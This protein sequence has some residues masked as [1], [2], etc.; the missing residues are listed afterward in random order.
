ME[1]AP[2]FLQTWPHAPFPSADF[3]LYPLA[4]INHSWE[5]NYM[6][7]PMS[8]AKKPR[9]LRVAGERLTQLE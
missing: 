6:L 8:S 1:A 2:G 7:S 9:N 3:A 5:Q 4:L